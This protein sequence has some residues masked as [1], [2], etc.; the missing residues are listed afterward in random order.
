MIR[1]S[2]GFVANYN[3]TASHNAYIHLSLMPAWFYFDRANNLAFHDL[4]TT[5]SPFLNLRSLLGLGHKFCPMPRFSTSCVKETFKRFH[6]DYYCKIFYANKDFS[7]NDQN[8][9]DPKMYVNSDWTPTDWMIPTAAVRR[10]N[11]FRLHIDALF[12]KRKVSSNLLSH[13]HLALRQLQLQ[14]EFL[15]VQCDKNLGPAILEYNVY[16]KRALNDHLLQTDTYRQLTSAVAKQY[17]SRITILI[18]DWLLKFHDD[19]N[20]NERK[21]IRTNTL[22]CKSPFPVF[23]LTMKVHKSPWKTR[24]I[25]SYSGC[26]LYSVAVW[27]DRKLQEV[28]VAQESYISSSKKLKDVLLDSAPFPKSALLFTADAVSYYTNINTAQALREIGNY[29]YQHEDRFPNIPIDALMN[30]LRLIMTNNVF[31]FGNTYWLQLSGTAMGTPPAC[32]YATLFFAIHEQRI[33]H[34]HPNVAFYKRYIDDVFGIWVP[35]PNVETDRNNWINFQRDMQSYHGIE[36]TFSSLNNSVDFLDTTIT[37]LDGNISTTLYEKAL[38]LYLYISP[39]SCHPPGVLTGLVLGNCHRI[40]TLC[41]DKNDAKRHLS[42]FYRR[43]LLRGYNTTTLLPLFNK[44]RDLATTR[45][46]I[47]NKDT[48]SDTRIFLHLSYNPRNPT[49]YQLQQGFRSYVMHPDYEKILSSI[50]NNE[51]EPIPIERMT[52]AY[53]RPHNLGNL[54]SYRNLDDSTG[55]PVS[56]FI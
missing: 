16:I 38:N 14:Q 48:S 13:Q 5:P 1:A 30:G 20:K 27:V 42:N 35:S 53:S 19:F 17:A 45:P 18:S 33:I 6:H 24:P 34:T 41:S 40:Y 7:N 50:T 31:T 11:Q 32:N 36:W 25:V 9:Y 26:L 44:A 21:Y 28:A 23:Y 15:V 39:H 29:L 56:S 46:A 47:S 4:T 37:I 51:G 54:L 49:S 52:V 43:L 3:F 12:R 22:K 2:F 55:P 10:F 8:D